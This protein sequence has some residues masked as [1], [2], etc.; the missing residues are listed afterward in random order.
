MNFFSESIIDLLNSEFPVYCN[1]YRVV[2]HYSMYSSML[3]VHITDILMKE[4]D[5]KMISGFVIEII[6]I[7]LCKIFLTLPF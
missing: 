3:T 5:K 7:L 4:N 2:K 1:F 6:Q